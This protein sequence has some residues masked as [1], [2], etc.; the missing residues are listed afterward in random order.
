MRE[1]ESY[2]GD[3]TNLVM[4]G[5]LA[6]CSCSAGV[7]KKRLGVTARSPT[8]SSSGS[9][10]A[11]NLPASYL[12]AADLSQSQSHPLQTQAIPRADLPESE[13]DEST[14]DEEEDMDTVPPPIATPHAPSQLNRPQ[15]SLSSRP[16]RTPMA[17]TLLIGST[18]PLHVPITQPHP[19]FQ[20][21]SAFAESSTSIPSSVYPPT[22]TVSF[23]DQLAR[24]SDAPPPAHTYPSQHF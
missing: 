1:L 7:L 12:R 16:Y 19:G 6:S 17:S 4:S 20:T 15:S 5:A 18:P 22:T 21:Q 13:T 9:S 14:T 24:S 11:G 3:P 23:P 2:A 10:A 8:S